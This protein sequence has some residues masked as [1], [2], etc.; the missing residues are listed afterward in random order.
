MCVFCI[1]VFV[2]GLALHAVLP[3]PPIS[4]RLGQFLSPEA[5]TRRSSILRTLFQVPYP[6]SPLLATLTKTA[7]VY[8]NNSRSGSNR[9]QQRRGALHSSLALTTVFK[10]FLFTPLRTLL[11]SPKTQLF[12]FQPIPHSLPKNTGSGGGWMSKRSRLY[13]DKFMERGYGMGGAFAVRACLGAR[14]KRT[15]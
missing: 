6:V 14:M 11:H 1:P 8:T 3:T 7:G 15:A 4:L 2:L 5:R 9:L 10:F 13:K 12:Y